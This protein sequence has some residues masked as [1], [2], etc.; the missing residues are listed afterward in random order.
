[1]I[2]NALN[3]IDKGPSRTLANATR[4]K[5]AFVLKTEEYLIRS[6]CT[7]APVNAK[8]QVGDAFQCTSVDNR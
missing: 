1:M 2:V 4:F 7:G 3:D 5:I 8:G 6:A